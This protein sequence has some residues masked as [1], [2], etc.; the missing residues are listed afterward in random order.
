MKK[1]HHLILLLLCTAL[2]AP[3]FAQNTLRI[4]IIPTGSDSFTVI[5]NSSLPF[6]LRMHN[7]STT[8][9]VD[10]VTFNYS[11]DS[12]G[13]GAPITYT[14]TNGVTGLSYNTVTD[15]IFGQDS[16]DV[17]VTIN[18]G[19]PRFKS[20]PSVVVI[21]PIRSNGEI[22]G[23]KLSFNINVLNPNGVEDPADVRL[24]AYI[25]EDKLLIT[26]H[27]ATQLKQLKIYDILGHEIFSKQNPADVT[28]LP[29]NAHGVYVAEIMY[30]NNQR[31]T[32]R[33]YY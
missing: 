2:S 17:T 15:T 16:I 27:P 5:K 23:N 8:H 26:R 31:N 13:I 3:A 4:E 18:A 14:D 22:T 32:F 6:T 19:E 7:D 9:Y 30:G 33:F 12:A 28:T 29:L 1:I 24:R 20:G 25:W 11:I 21:W 10:T